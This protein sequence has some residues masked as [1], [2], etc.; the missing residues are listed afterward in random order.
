[1]TDQQPKELRLKN[2]AAILDYIQRFSATEKAI[3]SLFV[4]GAV[5]TAVTMTLQVNGLFLTEIPG[6]GGT[7]HEGLIGLPHTVNPV[8]AVTDIDRDISSLVYA[9]LTKYQ[10]GTIV[11][12][13][14]QDWNISPDGLTY[15]FNLRPELEFH[16]GV[17][18]TTQDVLFTVSK[19]QDPALKSPRLADWAGISAT[20]TSPLTIQFTLKKPYSSFLSSTVVGIIPKHIWGSVSDDQFIFSEYNIK[21]IGAG[22]YRI[23]G[24]DRDKGG[25]PTDYHLSVWNGY[26]GDSPYISNVDF[27]FFADEDHALTAFGN[28]TIDSLAS[29]SSDAAVE[30]ASNT[31]EPYAISSAPLNRT[32]GVFFNQNSNRVLAD[33]VVRRALNMSVDRERIIDTVL[34]GYGQAVSG[35][36]PPELQIGSTTA[37][38][39]DLAGAQNLMKKNGWIIGSNGV[40]ET[41]VTKK[42]AT[43]TL[44]FTLYTSNTPDLKKTADLIKEDWARFGAAVTI[45]TFEPGDLYQNIIRTRNYDALLFGEAPGRNNDLYSFWHSSQRNAPGLNVAMYTNSKADKI[46]DSIRIATGTDAVASLYGQLDQLIRNEVPAIF[47]YTPDFIY[48]VPKT[49][50]GMALGTM[51]VPTDRFAS[52]GDWYLETEDVWDIFAH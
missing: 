15:T 9:G 8:L 50:R 21:P 23:I 16:D 49:L 33:L 20:T 39:T 10:N 19:I 13:L 4:A 29:V 52:I 47:L 12:D 3:F 6:H 44:S 27:S 22:P 28:G 11:P 51:V 7:L 26:H 36:L 37:V 25:I 35:L 17:P 42:S 48:A 31:G 34:G 14:A 40:Y 30:L 32:F 46:L 43:T 18:V 24:L 41:K 2:S 5:V 1:V 38:K 45:K